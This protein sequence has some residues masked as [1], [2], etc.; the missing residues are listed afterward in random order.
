MGEIER[1]GESRRVLARTGETRKESRRE[2]RAEKRR[3]KCKTEKGDNMKER[4]K[5]SVERGV[6]CIPAKIL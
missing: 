1:K 5:R 6:L 3:R 4:E 2:S